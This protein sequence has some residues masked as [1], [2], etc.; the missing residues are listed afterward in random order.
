M[1]DINQNFEISDTLIPMNIKP[2]AVFNLDGAA[3]AAMTNTLSTW[4]LVA[5]AFTAE[6]NWIP[7]CTFTTGVLTLNKGVYRIEFEAAV[8]TSTPAVVAVVAFR[9]ND[10]TST[11]VK[12]T[13]TAADAA[14]TNSGFTQMSGILEIPSNGTALNLQV[15]SDRAAVFRAATINGESARGASLIINQLS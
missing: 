10:G 3:N 11:W 5:N 15:Y 6:K 8:G 14:T 1:V 2:Y 12:S 7:G 4:T 13:L 9:L